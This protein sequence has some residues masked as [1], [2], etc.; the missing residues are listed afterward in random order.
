M[1]T[2]Q[3]QDVRSLTLAERF[4]VI[5]VSGLCRLLS[6]ADNARLF[7][8]CLDLLEPHGRLVICDSFAGSDDHD[9]SLALYTLGLAARSHAE[10]LWSAADYERWLDG[11]GFTTAA[12]VLA[13]RPGLTALIA[14]TAPHSH[15]CSV[16][17]SRSS[18]SHPRP[19][20]TTRT[21]DK[22]PS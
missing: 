21:N 4:D 20:P 11:A 10:A 17:P 7:A 5:V 8:R 18:P 13:E 9:G 19:R 15:T 16:S 1:S 12:V 14:S 2:S 6:E 22:G 3:A